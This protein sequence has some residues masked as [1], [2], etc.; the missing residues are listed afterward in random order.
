MPLLSTN[1]TIIDDDDVYE[2]LEVMDWLSSHELLLSP[3]EIFDLW[4]VEDSHGLP[5]PPPF[6][7]PTHRIGGY[8]GINGFDY[9][10]DR[11]Y[12]CQIATII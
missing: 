10:P 5:E 1:L 11:P 8:T 9:E 7:A 3:E 6:P 12:V 2:L 4:A